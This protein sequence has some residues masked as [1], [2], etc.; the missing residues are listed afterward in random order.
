MI[1]WTSVQ[2]SDSLTLGTKNEQHQGTNVI[3]SRAYNMNIR[4]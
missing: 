2:V 1:D 3:E 4:K